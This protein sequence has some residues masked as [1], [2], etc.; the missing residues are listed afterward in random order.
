MTYFRDWF[1]RDA[2][3]G[4][5]YYSPSKRSISWDK[6]YNDY[7]DFF[8]GNRKG[9]P[10]NMEEAAGLIRTMSKVMGVSCDLFGTFSGKDRILLPTHLL[11]DKS[12]DVFIG[13]ALQ[14]MAKYVHQNSIERQKAIDGSRGKPTLK[15]LVQNIL[16]EERVNKIMSDSTPGYLRFIEK[17]K[18][19]K[20]STRPTHAN[21]KQHLIDLF[22]RIIRYPED[23]TEE[24]LEKFK[25]PINGIKKILS[26]SNGIPLGL[27]DCMKVASK[28]TK[29][30]ETYIPPE[31]ETSDSGSGDGVPGDEG[32][33][34]DLG[35]S[36]EGSMG[37]GDGPS[38]SS[39]DDFIKDMITS[40]KEDIPLDDPS[41]SQFMEEL[42]H[43][44]ELSKSGTSMAS[45]VD[46][47]HMKPNKYS[48]HSYELAKK[49]IDLSKAHVLAT[50]L[51]RKNRDYQF[52]LKS[53]RSGR[54]DT[55]KL[56]EAKQG[57]STIYERIGSVK[58]DKLCVGVLVDESGSMHGS[59]ASAARQA[60]IYLDESLK[61]VPD[62]ELF[63]Y[64]HTADV[65]C[66]LSDS[67]EIR[68]SGSR[69]TQLLV[70]KEPGIQ[71]S[72]QL[73]DIQ[74]RSENRDGVA[75]IAAA[76][77]IRKFTQDKGVFVIISDGSPHA[78]SYAGDT[79]RKHVKKMA[80]EI[81]AMGF[82]VIQVTIGGY[83][84]HDMFKD[85]IDIDS[86]EEFPEKF[87]GFLRKKVN[88]LIKE[89]VM[90]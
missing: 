31:E 90:L 74:G 23:I 3:Y 51:K 7:S 14:N 18:K 80:N 25:D 36:S 63:I 1:G 82:Q 66:I 28:I 53:M 61:G 76:K 35:G 49:N 38:E 89:K 64:G 17:Y 47:I 84:S 34:D 88:S 78:T 37:S 54:L 46:I 87:V 4:Y 9:K 32:D 71:T 68:C 29:V 41:F 2:D 24:E 60:A 83:R 19:D 21:D 8:F 27:E 6:G 58:T 72:H 12:T 55:N 79:A 59:K 26:K 85:V 73:G 56:A 69:S 39:D 20:Y 50:L 15:K 43:I 48:I 57:V 11:K 40:M 22:D 62:V 13:A 33:T 30:I 45:K 5:S 77:Q 52:A 44:E 10:V 67:R 65:P 75:M 81:E 86:V 16:N 42:K 70:Y